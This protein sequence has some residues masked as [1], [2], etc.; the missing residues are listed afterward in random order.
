MPVDVGVSTS[1]VTAVVPHDDKAAT[2][3]NAS[4]T[5]PSAAGANFL[6]SIESFIFQ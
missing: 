6:L 3:S 5:H 4:M 2:N 1:S